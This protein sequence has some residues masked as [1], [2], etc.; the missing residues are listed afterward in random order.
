MTAGLPAL[1][2]FRPSPPLVE[3]ANDD[4]PQARASAAAAQ[5]YDVATHGLAEGQPEVED[6]AVRGDAAA[7]TAALQSIAAT[8]C[9]E[10]V[11]IL[12]S[13]TTPM[14][15]LLGLIAAFGDAVLPTLTAT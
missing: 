10:L 7:C 6:Y 1:L 4:S 3:L 13:A 9:D 14:D 5:S 15:A 11:V 12:G 8:G 2:L